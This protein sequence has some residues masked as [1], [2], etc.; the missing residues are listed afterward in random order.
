MKPDTSLPKKVLA[1]K[2]AYISNLLI[3]C[4]LCMLFPSAVQANDIPPLPDVTEADGKLG[5]CYSFYDIDGEV[6][7]TK[8]YA[9]G[10]RWDRFDFRWN[11]IEDTRV[12][13]IH[14]WPLPRATSIID[15]R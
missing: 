1:P 4:A 3:I 14:N 15:H 9:A 11:V 6:L 13:H 2:L 10:S 7:A 5:I 12:L 8:A